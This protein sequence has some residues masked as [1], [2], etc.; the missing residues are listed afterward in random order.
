M[1]LP[2]SSHRTAIRWGT[3]WRCI[4]AGNLPSPFSVDGQALLIGKQWMWT[5]LKLHNPQQIN[6]K[7]LLKHWD[8]QPYQRIS[9][10]RIVDGRLW[11]TSVFCF[12]EMPCCS[13]VVGSVF[14]YFYNSCSISDHET[15]SFRSSALHKQPAVPRPS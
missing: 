9:W 4:A 13:H 8:S 11:T 14:L 12:D 3:K 1:P 7:L 5:L 15:T 10:S 6:P 2:V